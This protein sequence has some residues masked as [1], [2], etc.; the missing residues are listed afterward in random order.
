MSHYFG[1]TGPSWTIDTACSLSLAAINTACRAIWSGECSCA[2][3][4]G[5]NVISS[6]FNYHNLATAGFLSLSGKCKPF[7]ED[8]DG[9]CRG[10]AVV[11]SFLS[12]YW[13]LLEI[14]IT[15]MALLL[16]LLPTKITTLAVLRP[17]TW[18]PKLSF[19]KR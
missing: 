13:M 15:S 6:L 4:G 16:G 11:W 10:E 19:T 18:V 14:M 17:H 8:A 2:V 9:Y 7:D 5:T 1:W 12:C 3:A